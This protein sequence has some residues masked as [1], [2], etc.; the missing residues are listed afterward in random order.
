MPVR[1]STMN[2]M[3]VNISPQAGNGGTK[4]NILEELKL[5]ENVTGAL[6]S[7]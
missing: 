6:K 7:I 2:L 5:I 3:F 4:T 1:E